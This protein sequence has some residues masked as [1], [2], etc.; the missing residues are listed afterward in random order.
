MKYYSRLSVRE[1]YF[2]PL[3]FLERQT[4]SLS[5]CSSC[6]IPENDGHVQER[7]INHGATTNLEDNLDLP[8]FR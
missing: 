4:R 5:L 1:D 6:E 7:L 3:P 2:I 8:S